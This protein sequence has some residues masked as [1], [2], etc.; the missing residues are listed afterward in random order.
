[1]LKLNPATC[2]LIIIDLQEGILPLAGGPHPASDVVRHAGEMAAHFRARDST[3]ILIRVGWSADQAEMLKQPTDTP[4][5]RRILPENWWNYPPALDKQ[6][7]DI[8][9]IKRQW[10]AF[11]GTD[12]EMQLRRRKID[13]LVICG[14]CTNIGVESTARSA[15]EMGFSVIIASDA[16]SANST[17]QHQSSINFIFPRIARV[18]TSE[19]IITALAS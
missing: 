3:V 18:R 1:M 10:G 5:T 6:D 13:S 7:S 16:C 17:E 8:E 15:W 14:I 2:A 19:Q 11:Y 12:L 9:I 4:A